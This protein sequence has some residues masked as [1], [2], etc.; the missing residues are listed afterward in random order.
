M[1]V[2]FPY[3]KVVQIF[4]NYDDEGK[5]VLTS[6]A[7][8]RDPIPHPTTRSVTA[9]AAAISWFSG[10]TTLGVNMKAMLP[11]YALVKANTA[12]KK[13]YHHSDAKKTCQRAKN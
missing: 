12:M 5:K 13:M 7:L 11:K 8:S 4:C 6:G 3:D 1:L 10:L 9:N 2:V